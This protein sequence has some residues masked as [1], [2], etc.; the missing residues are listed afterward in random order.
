L[1]LQLRGILVILC[2]LRDSLAKHPDQPKVNSHD[3]FSLH[4]LICFLR[5]QRVLVF[6]RARV[7]EREWRDFDLPNPPLNERDYI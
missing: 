1:Q 6:L 3:L 4:E 2:K 7:R 5:K